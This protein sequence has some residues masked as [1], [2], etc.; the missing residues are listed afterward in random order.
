MKYSVSQG[1]F[2]Y[3]AYGLHIPYIKDPPLSDD[4]SLIVNE[5][6]PLFGIGWRPTMLAKLPTQF[7]FI[8]PP[9]I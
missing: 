1:N 8:N 2:Y 5:K 4:T 7:F 9:I 3:F 6:T